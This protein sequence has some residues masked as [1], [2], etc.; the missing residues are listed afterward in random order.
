[1]VCIA[2]VLHFKYIFLTLIID[3]IH[4][5]SVSKMTY[6]VWDVKRYYAVPSA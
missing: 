3:N 5:S 6:T 2:I 1:V 4:S